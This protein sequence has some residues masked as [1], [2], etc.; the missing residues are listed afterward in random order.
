MLGTA[1]GY[2]RVQLNIAGMIGML[3][4]YKRC[5]LI[6]VQKNKR[7]MPFQSLAARTIGYKNDN[8]K[9]NDLDISLKKSKEID[10]KT[11]V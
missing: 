2:G 5:G 9:N 4:R 1:A 7:I 8:V 3:A 11:L 10:N 6:A